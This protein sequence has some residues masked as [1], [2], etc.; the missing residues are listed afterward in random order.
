MEIVQSS[1]VRYAGFWI[2][3]VAAFIDAILLGI[4][5]GIAF[6]S[7]VNADPT[8]MSG[9]TQFLPIIAGWLYYALME[10][11]SYQATLGKKV[12]GIKVTTVEGKRMTFLNATGRHF[13]KF[14]SGIIL[15]IGYLMVAFSAKKQ[16]LHDL[17]AKTYVVKAH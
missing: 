14:I 3:V 10:S 6:G 17:L 2:R 1:T 4:V 8:Q 15:G 12:V 16:G 11:S 5:F 13:A 9:A 7:T